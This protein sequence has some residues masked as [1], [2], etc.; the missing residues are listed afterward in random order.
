MKIFKKYIR[1]LKLM[2]DKEASQCIE[3]GH[4]KS[5]YK[6]PDNIFF[7][8]DK[9]KYLDREIIKN[10]YFERDST[11]LIKQLL[12]TSDVFLDIG[13]NIGYYSLVASSLVGCRGEVIAFE[14]TTFYR[15]TLL[16]NIKQNSSTN[17]TV[18]DFGLSEDNQNLKISLGESSA[19]LHP[20]DGNFGQRIETIN[21]MRL[22]D[23]FDQLEIAKVDFIKIDVDGHEPSVLK[24]AEAT[25]K[26]FSPKILLEVSHLNYLEH[27]TTAWDF[28]E[29]VLSLGYSIYDEHELRPLTTRHDFLVKC[30]NFA[31]SRNIL[32]S[33]NTPY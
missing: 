26:K 13:A 33:K 11:L 10:G 14:P 5:L 8:L 2:L 22:D 1:S 3:K 17:I 20:V 19:T 25:L 18:K 29:Y 23:I 9:R 4:E 30:G 16:K 6:T 27:G 7:W 21:L 31:Y 15:N 24:G 32:L 12:R 28:F